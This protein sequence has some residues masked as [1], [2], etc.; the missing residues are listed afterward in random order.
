MKNK[1]PIDF[2]TWAMLQQ[3]HQQAD[4]PLLKDYVNQLI[5]MVTQKDAGQRGK[6]LSWDNLE[7]VEMGIICE[8]TALVLSG[9]LD[10]LEK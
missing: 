9:E 3:G 8:A 2:I 5:Q 1:P 10:K 7:R 6:N 4:I